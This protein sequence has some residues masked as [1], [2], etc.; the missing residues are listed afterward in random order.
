MLIDILFTLGTIGFLLADVKQF[1]KLHKHCIKTTA[2][3]RSHLKIKIFSLFCVIIGYVLSNL[4]IS[5]VVA[6]VQLALTFGILY[7]TYKYYGDKTANKTQEAEE[8]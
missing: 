1:Y 3:S 8:W 6:S 5:S 2:I 7:Y 4:H